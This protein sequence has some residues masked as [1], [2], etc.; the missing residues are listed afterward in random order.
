VIQIRREEELNSLLELN[1]RLS[2]VFT[3]WELVVV[4]AGADEKLQSKAEDLVQNQNF[5]NARILL[6]SEKTQTSSGALL[7]AIR[8]AIGDRITVVLDNLSDY[9]FLDNFY[10][11]VETQD[12]VFAQPLNTSSKNPIR[13]FLTHI[14]NIGYRLQTGT[15]PNGTE[16][17]LIDMS[18][19]ML[20][21][22]QKMNRPE[23]AIRNIGLYK[24]MTVDSYSFDS[25]QRATRKSVSESF[26]RG[27][28]I[29]FSASS[30]PLRLIS[31]VAL[32]A[33]FLNLVYSIYVLTV[34]AT[35]E[36]ERGWTSMSLQISGMFFLISLVLSLISEFL[37]FMYRAIGSDEPTFV[38]NEIVSRQVGLAG[39][40]NISKLED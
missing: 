11:S 6:T 40:L 24:G 2:R 17:S 35:Q 31:V 28:E 9:S 36:V 14:F 4:I 20:N 12:A 39:K 37:I 16:S 13:Y 19:E 26:G 32:V 21:F 5:I 33:A 38:K 34:S 25:P 1:Q 10:E 15:V 30:S 18:R 29:L 3:N 7:A 8:S 23:I 22:L 27:M